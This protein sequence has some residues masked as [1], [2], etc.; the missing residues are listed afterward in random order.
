[1]RFHFFTDRL[2][3]R[4]ARFLRDR[5]GLGAVEFAVLAPVLI[6]MFVALADL[7]L[8]IYQNMQ[9][10]SAAQYRARKRSARTGMSTFRSRSEG[11]RMAKALTR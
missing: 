2:G 11:R 6:L 9:V 3:G 1:M 4:S 8:G 7:G 5:N 10:D